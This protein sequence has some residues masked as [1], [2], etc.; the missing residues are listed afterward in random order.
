MFQSC[1]GVGRVVIT[2]KTALRSQR[3]PQIIK[4]KLYTL[5]SES[6]RFL[7]SSQLIRKS[8]LVRVHSGLASL[9]YLQAI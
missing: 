1:E 5:S 3:T 2:S 6:Q 8:L 7:R 9:V 4:M